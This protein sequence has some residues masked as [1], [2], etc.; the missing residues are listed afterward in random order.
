VKEQW[1]KRCAELQAELAALQ[2]Q[3]HALLA[4]QGS[5]QPRVQWTRYSKRF[6]SVLLPVVALLATGGALYGQNVKADIY[7][8]FIDAMGRVGIGTSSPNATLDVAGTLSVAGNADLATATIKGLLITEGTIGIGTASSQATVTTPNGILQINR[9][10]STGSQ[11]LI[12]SNPNAN[13]VAGDGVSQSYYLGTAP[14]TEMASIL[15][16]NQAAG[17]LSN[18]HLSIL[19]RKGGKM[20]EKLRIGFSDH[21]EDLRILSDTHPIL[22]SSTWRDFSKEGG[23]QNTAEISNDTANFKALMIAGNSS[24]EDKRRTV[25]IYDRLNVRSSLNVNGKPVPV[26]SETL[27]MVRG[28]VTANGS[29]YAGVGYST[30]RVNEGVY[31]IA[32]DP[33]FSLIPGAS[34]TQIFQGRDNNGKDIGLA[35][36][37]IDARGGDTRDNAVIVFLSDKIL[38][39]K[40]GD[41][42]GTA[43]DRN[44]SFIAIGPS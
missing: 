5:S 28:V 44:F 13:P 43:R 33:P 3:V 26:G 9:S 42:G 18:G 7:A 35:D 15:A 29:N 25:N 27:R 6:L 39:V 12:L 8:L 34:V 32:F 36:A 40:T 31:D 14:G 4:T 37:G 38:R 21:P 20:T 2:K 22:F 30:K 16:A 11:A 24:S 1:E 41:N 23:Q 10:N 17:D 19:T